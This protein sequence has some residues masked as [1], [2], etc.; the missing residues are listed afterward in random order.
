MITQCSHASAGIPRRKNYNTTKLRGTNH[1]NT[2]FVL[3]TVPAFH[4]LRW[5]ILLSL[6]PSFMFCKIF[7]LILNGIYVQIHGIII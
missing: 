3:M 7:V 4:F 1:E 6:L 5:Q 2:K